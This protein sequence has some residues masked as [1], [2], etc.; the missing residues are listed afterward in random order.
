M[1]YHY[2]CK[3]KNGGHRA[4]FVNVFKWIKKKE[5]SANLT[6]IQKDDKPASLRLSNTKRLY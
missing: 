4:K 2:S 3:R 1:D 6:I 5:D